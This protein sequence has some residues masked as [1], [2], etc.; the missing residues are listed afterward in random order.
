MQVT[1]ILVPGIRRPYL[2]LCLLVT[3]TPQDRFG[4]QCMLFAQQE[5]E[6]SLTMIQ[7]CK[8]NQNDPSGG[9]RKVNA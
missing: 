9:E 6:A 2:P 1:E 5:A 3:E 8:L 4:H 7:R